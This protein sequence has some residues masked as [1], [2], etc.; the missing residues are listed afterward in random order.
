MTSERKRE[1][2]R[3]EFLGRSA[4]ILA[5]MALAEPVSAGR[6][7][8]SPGN[9]VILGQIGCG[10]RGSMVC[11][12]IA[13]LPNVEFAYVCD[14]EDARANALQAALE[15][16]TGRKPAAVREMRKLF[17]DKNVDAVIIST[18]EQWHALASI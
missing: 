10:G 14:P 12:S 4:G 17:D 7:K 9:K 13:Q 18:P 1:I 6:T 11:Q 15:K 8:T 2:G 16:D 3:R 5:G